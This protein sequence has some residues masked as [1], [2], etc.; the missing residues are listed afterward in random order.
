MGLYRNPQPTI[1]SGVFFSNV[2]AAGSPQPGIFKYHMTLQDGMVWLLY[3][4][5]ASEID[6]NSWCQAL[7][8]R[9]CL[10]FL[11]TIQ[12]AKIPAGAVESFYGVAAGVYATCDHLWLCQRR[13]CQTTTSRGTK[14]ARMK[15]I[16]I[17][18]ILPYHIIWNPLMA[19]PRPC[20]RLNQP[21][22]FIGNKVPGITF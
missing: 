13:D 20:S 14:E 7:S 6:A 10:A 4:I 5:P 11:G 12:I 17:F 8:C 3:A 18:Q 1:Q 21:P 2:V 16:R 22:S 15:T 19:Q 9:E